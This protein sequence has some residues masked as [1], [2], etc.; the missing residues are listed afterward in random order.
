[1]CFLIESN[2]EDKSVWVGEELRLEVSNS[3][4]QWGL[5]KEGQDELNVLFTPQKFIIYNVKKKK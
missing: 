5:L 1:M 4:W 3:D 2:V